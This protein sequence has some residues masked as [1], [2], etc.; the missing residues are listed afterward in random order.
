M[1][2]ISSD[3][4]YDRLVGHGLFSEKLPPAFSTESFL[5]Y[6]KTKKPMNFRAVW[7]PYAVYESMRNVNT[8]RIIGIPNPMGYERL[9][10][11]I[12]DNWEK[13][14]DH[15]EEKTANDSHKI[16]RIHVR[17]MAK[18]PALFEM[19]YKNWRMDGT[20]DPDLLIG[21]RY[22]VSADISKCFPSIYSHA[23]AWALAGK[24]TAKT[25]TQ[26]TNTW[27]NGIDKNT[28]NLK[29]GET[30]GLLIGPHASNILSEVIL[31]TI[32]SK[33]GKK[34]KYVRNI[35]D[36]T[37]FVP[38]KMQAEFFLLDLNRELKEFG[39]YLNHKK[40]N[41]SELPQG[42]VEGWVRKIR[43][44]LACTD[45]KSRY[46]NYLQLQSFLDFCISLVVSTGENASILL[47]GIKAIKFY[48]MSMSARN[49]MKKT[50]LSLALI[51]P[52]LVPILNDFLFSPEKSD[53]TDIEFIERSIN[54]IYE[55][56]FRKD[57]YEA[58]AYAIF[59]AIKTKVKIREFNIEK[60][61]EKNDCVLLTMT[62]LYCR[63]N[64]LAKETKELKTLALTL[65]RNQQM[66]EFWP[67][68]YECL[69]AN[70]LTGDWKPM[71]KNSV[72]FIKK[73]YL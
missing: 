28:R 52:Y 22:V 54:L 50:L 29:N 45:I 46:L 40:T 6:C 55:N 73:E 8:P 39:L 37:C 70:L 68:V 60:I 61:L 66:D 62:L 14:C 4:I 72:S 32:D 21:A 42:S 18:T 49:Y 3:E 64:N 34:W 2:E 15:F 57:H 26:K 12:A 25:S 47:Y 10:R 67:F 41:I 13:I 31:C 51:Y 43:D 33:L 24:E 16:S 63:R 19:N 65:K 20:P 9:C 48:R 44:R 36:Y 71:K 58:V 30:H 59:Y 53:E 17:K 56:Y 69:N 23:I 5:D 27:W 11:C 1:R 7:Y 38:D 35:D